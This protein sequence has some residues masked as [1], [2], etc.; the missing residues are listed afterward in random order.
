MKK[1]NLK[2][3]LENEFFI[4]C[5]P[6]STD[7]FVSYCKERGIHTSKEQL[8]Q[9]EKLGI[10]YPVAPIKYPKL[11]IKVEYIDEIGRAHV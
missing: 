11:R 1:N 4:T 5:Q 8:E 3:L 10:F 9:F 2:Y 6:L 7:R